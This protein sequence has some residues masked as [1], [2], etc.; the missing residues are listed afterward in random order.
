VGREVTEAVAIALIAAIGSMLTA[1]ITGVALV[2]VNQVLATAKRTE[3]TAEK[4]QVAVDGA[5]HELI[6]AKVGQAHAEGVTTG[7]QAQRDRAG[8]PQP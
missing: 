5:M 6:A 1:A 7:E 2:K 4:T 8:D 3:A